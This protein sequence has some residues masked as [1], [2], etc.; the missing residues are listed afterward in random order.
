M[1]REALGEKVLREL[2]KRAKAAGTTEA[3]GFRSILRSKEMKAKLDALGIDA[4][5]LTKSPI[6]SPALQKRV[7]TLRGR[8]QPNQRFA[9]PYKGMANPADRDLARR[10]SLTPDDALALLEASQKSR[11]AYLVQP[12]S[13]ARLLQGRYET[14]AQFNPRSWFDG[15]SSGDLEKAV[16]ASQ[17]AAAG[18]HGAPHW[19]GP[20][21]KKERA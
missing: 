15:A 19:F 21:K 17:S 1:Q 9:D 11:R 3:E 16:I 5:G 20:R 10:G 2:K 8:A 13:Q 14:G 7:D 4:V 18:L 12:D 6:E